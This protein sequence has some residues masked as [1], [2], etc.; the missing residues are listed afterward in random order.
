MQ[1]SHIMAMAVQRLFPGTQVT[2][3]PWI[4]HGFF[5]DFDTPKPLSPQDLKAIQKDMRRIIRADL[6][7]VREEVRHACPFMLLPDSGSELLYL[8]LQGYDCLCSS[9]SS[10][11]DRLLAQQSRPRVCLSR[12]CVGLACAQLGPAS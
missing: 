7:F 4:E 11:A 1:C 10:A 9:C 3:G 8:A 5:Y 12:V 2:I 6:P